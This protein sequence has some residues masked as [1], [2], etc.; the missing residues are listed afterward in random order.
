MTDQ[1]LDIFKLGLLALLYLFFARVLWA[2]WSEV[3]PPAEIRQGS[4]P[5]P[6][7]AAGAARSGPQVRRGAP[8]RLVVLE[9]KELKGRQFAIAHGLGI[10][11]EPDN[12][13]VIQDDKFVSSHHLK[14]LVH[15]GQIVV[16]DLGSTNGTI[17]NGARLVGERPL[18]N[19]DRIQVGFT[20]LE[21]R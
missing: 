3:R 11:R 6:T 14:V 10:G 15:D 17:L 16:Q 2:V 21:A 12:T 7:P 5:T 9:P 19:G 4:E 20:V 13:I 8:T 1:A 18:R